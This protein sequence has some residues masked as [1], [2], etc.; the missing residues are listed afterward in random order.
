VRH[1][2]GDLLPEMYD[3]WLEE[4]REHLRQRYDAAEEPY[5]RMMRLYALCGERAKAMH[6][7]HSCASLLMRKV[8]GEPSPRTQAAYEEAMLVDPDAVPRGV[9]PA[10]AGRPV[11]TADEG[12]V[13]S[14]ASAGQRAVRAGAAPF[15]GRAD[16]LARL[17]TAWEQASAG[18]PS[19]AFVSGDSGIGKSA[20]VEAFVRWLPRG[21]ARVAAP[22]AT[23]R[24]D[25][26]RSLP[27]RRSCGVQ[28][29]P[30]DPAT[31]PRSRAES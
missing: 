2:R 17:R 16:E 8:G 11:V 21:E 15:V 26:S 12:R 31:W 6:V 7:Y 23:P 4:P 9:P 14:S 18:T 30:P 20:V 1:Y 10:D 29:W 5:R 22:T 3:G 24:R 13:T 28:R 25:R 19:M 27:R